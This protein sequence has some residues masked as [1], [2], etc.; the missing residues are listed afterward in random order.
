MWL[1]GVSHVKNPRLLV[2]IYEEMQLRVN[3]M[4]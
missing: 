1:A 2:D 3:E 4:K